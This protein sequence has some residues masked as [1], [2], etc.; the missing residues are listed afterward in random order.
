MSSNLHPNHQSRRGAAPPCRGMGSHCRGVPVTL[1]VGP[2]E[3]GTSSLDHEATWLIGH[4]ERIT[5]Y[6]LWDDGGELYVDAMLHVSCRYLR[7]DGAEAA[8]A[9]HGYRGPA[10]RG[11]R[12]PEQPR[13]LGGGR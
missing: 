9:I 4:T 12:R 6:D 7:Q 11:P 5:F 8:C 13:R 3:E 10:P 2:L 1:R